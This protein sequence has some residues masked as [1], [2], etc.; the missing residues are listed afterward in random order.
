VKLLGCSTLR[1][2]DAEV[3]LG[4]VEPAG[5]DR[6]VDEDQVLPSALEPIDRTLAA[7][8]GA[9]VDDHEDALGGG[10]GLDAHELLDE[11][12][13]GSMPSL[14]AQRSKILAR[15]ASHAAR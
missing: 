12:I 9:V 11:R 14:G 2:R 1:W 5:V 6:G 10:V 8:R 15:R 3:D 7:V 13:E 4:L